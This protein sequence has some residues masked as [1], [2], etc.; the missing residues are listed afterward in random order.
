MAAST[1]SCS[2]SGVPQGSSTDSRSMPWRYS[3]ISTTSRS[4][5]SA[6]AQTHSGN[7]IV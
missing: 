4:G 2:S 5:V 3:S 7:S 6:I 1:S